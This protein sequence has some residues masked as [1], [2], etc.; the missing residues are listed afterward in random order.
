LSAAEAMPL[1]RA[2]TATMKMRTRKTLAFRKLLSTDLFY[3]VRLNNIFTRP[4]QTD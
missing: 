4:V 1:I 2:A 3:R